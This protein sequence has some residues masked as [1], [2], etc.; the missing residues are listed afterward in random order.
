MSATSLSPKK[1]TGGSRRKNI[2][3]PDEGPF[4]KIRSVIDITMQIRR[5]VTMVSN[6]WSW[7][8]ATTT[9]FRMSLPGLMRVV[10]G[11]ETFTVP[12]FLLEELEGATDRPFVP[13][14][15]AESSPRERS[16]GGGGP[17]GIALG[18]PTRQVTEVRVRCPTPYFSHVLLLVKM[19]WLLRLHSACCELD[20][21]V[22]SMKNIMLG[23]Q[24]VILQQHAEHECDSVFST[25]VSE[26]AG[27][28]V[29][30][31]SI[32]DDIVDQLQKALG[33]SWRAF[34]QFVSSCDSSKA[35]HVSLMD[36]I[37]SPKIVPTDDL[38]VVIDT[39]FLTNFLR[40]PRS[41]PAGKLQEFIVACR[42]FGLAPLEVPPLR[43]A[44]DLVAFS[45][46]KT[47]HEYRVVISL[48]HFL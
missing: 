17:L 37:N 44:R 20:Y 8:A 48:P 13:S 24:Y 3:E 22:C 32:F 15:C 33:I 4:F 10:C 26:S 25:N 12:G 2:K 16:Q 45:T 11:S 42:E 28:F 38:A 1:M 6:V 43:G 29:N 21:R 14:L 27:S 5:H 47:D 46:A 23:M 40:Q 39:I 36:S 41:G 18:G 19:R 30:L 31:D 9:P 7:T 35:M 34:L